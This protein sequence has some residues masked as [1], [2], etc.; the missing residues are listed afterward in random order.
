MT[1]FAATLRKLKE[2][3]R[4][5]A[6][7]SA[8]GIDFTSNDYLGFAS[9]PV[10]RET[11][12]IALEAGLALGSGGSRLL[13]GNHPEHAL[14]EEAA[15]R[16]FG[17]EQ[18]LFFGSGF[19]ANHALMTALPASHDI[20]L[21]DALIHASLREGIQCNPARHARLPHHDVN[22]FEEALKK[23][24]E[25]NSS[26][27]TGWVVVESV[28]SMDGDVAPLRDILSLCERY[29]A[30]LVVDE[31]HATGVFG[32]QGKGFTHGLRSPHLITMHTCGKGLGVA[33]ALV[34]ASDEVIQTL[35][36]KARPFI[37]S[38][39]S[40]PLQAV[41][42]GKAL[43]LCAAAD[44]RR[45][46][47]AHLCDM[48]RH[49]FPAPSS[50]TPIIPVMMGDEQR[51]VHAAAQLQE[52]GFDIRAIRPPTVPSGSSRLRITL[53]AMLRDDDVI[54]LGQALREL[55]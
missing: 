43:E 5:R 15:A 8:G 49:V 34:C 12:M 33:G 52:R 29:H 47:L 23:H 17:S 48:A 21:Y 39:A 55:A 6:L 31:A 14:L 16:F 22:A 1:H 45:A 7:S 18:S 41:L 2:E 28:A 51:A 11:A 32:E 4:F 44:D 19:M 26:G 54:A 25:K 3:G 24:A 50:P 9:H 20:I 42:V 36:N 40:M 35:I 27:A 30:M 13:R 53:N 46:R 38:T 37:Y 10:L